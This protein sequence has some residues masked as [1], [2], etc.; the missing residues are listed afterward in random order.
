MSS[1]TL[2]RLLPKGMKR[3][4]ITRSWGRTR[5]KVADSKSRDSWQR[6]LW[7]TG[8]DNRGRDSMVATDN[9]WADIHGEA[10]DS[11]VDYL[12]EI[13]QERGHITGRDI[14]RAMEAALQEVIDAGSDQF[15]QRTRDMGSSARSQALDTAGVNSV[16]AATNRL[17]RYATLRVEAQDDF[18]D[19]IRLNYEDSMT[20]IRSLPGNV[21]EDLRDKLIAA[22][23]V[24]AD[25]RQVI[26]AM[27]GDLIDQ[28]DPDG[29]MDPEAFR[30]AV[31]EIWDKTKS[32]LQRTVR[33]ESI[34]NY[35][36]TQ[37]QEWYDQGIR[38][39]TR[40]SINDTK[41]CPTCRTLSR[42]GANEYEIA[43]L[44]VLE[45]PV[46]EDPASPGS[47]LTHP[48]CRCWF[49]PI[50][51]DM[52]EELE[53]LERELFQDMDG[54][55]V[56]VTDVP[57]DSQETVKE[58]VKDW[59]AQDAAGADFGFVE[60]ITQDPDWQKFRLEELIDEDPTGATKRLEEEIS[61]GAVIEWTNPDTE[62]TLISD[63]AKSA[64]FVS[65]PFARRQ[66]E[67]RWDQEPSLQDW[68]ESRYNDKMAETRMTL[69]ENGV[70]IIGV[71]P[72]FVQSA[73][74]SSRD[75]F[76]EAHAHYMVDPVL[77]VT[78]DQLAYTRLRDHVFGGVEY[79][80]RGGVH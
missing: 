50:L 25:S 41:T 77:L 53:N 62:Q 18:G 78:L 72:F 43:D 71:L 4:K 46:T 60:D 61:D 11:F 35:A 51:E 19:R 52:W 33:T 28:I 64:N 20:R 21:V 34:N 13:H 15:L 16:T 39:V 29:V 56:T 24:G 37:L 3:N 79:I 74:E 40:H 7:W 57:L 38:R 12:F 14:E 30:V 2:F 49:R 42:P 63:E 10:G 73:G 54:R 55:K 66:G 68:W 22:I 80:E 69:E 75:Y 67:I 1:N 17:M 44:L 76:I 8:I 36:K 59:N 5:G 26:R 70:E 23:Q 32:D 45:H 58:V 47:F 31:R 48:N 6:R 65:M 27:I 9:A